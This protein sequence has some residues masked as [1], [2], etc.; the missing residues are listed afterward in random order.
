[1]RTKHP[2]DIK[3]VITGTQAYGPATKESDLDIVLVKKE[4]LELSEFLSK[5]KISPYQ[6]E[7]QEVYKENAGYYFKLGPLTINIIQVLCKEELQTWKV[8]TEQMKKEE[9]VINDRAK[10]IALFKQFK[11][12]AEEKIYAEAADDFIL[13]NL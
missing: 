5:H 7:G 3:M 13:D 11:G 8:A 10:R 6:T 4:V 9:F 2:F 1:M 12:K